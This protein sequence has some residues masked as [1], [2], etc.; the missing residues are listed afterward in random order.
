MEGPE[1]NECRA[2]RQHLFREIFSRRRIASKRLR[3]VPEIIT[4]RSPAS[5]GRCRIR[6]PLD[7]YRFEFPGRCTRSGMAWR[8]QML[9]PRP[10]QMIG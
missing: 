10:N 8:Q 5:H 2:N 1:L 3:G 9:A 7:R 6:Q 4:R